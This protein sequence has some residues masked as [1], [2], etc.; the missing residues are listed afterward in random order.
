MSTLVENNMY[1]PE[2]VTFTKTLR[3]ICAWHSLKGNQLKLQERFRHTYL[4]AAPS[5]R[6]EPQSV[7]VLLSTRMHL[8]SHAIYT[9]DSITPLTR[10]CRKIYFAGK[11]MESGHNVK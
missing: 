11:W 5:T 1:S 8:E 9:S 3:S 6:D 10:K 7:E 4:T 2:I